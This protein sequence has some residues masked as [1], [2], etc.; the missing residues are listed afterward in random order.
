[1]LHVYVSRGSEL[2]AGKFHAQKLFEQK[3]TL[4]QSVNFLQLLHLTDAAGHAVSLARCSCEPHLT[5][6]WLLTGQAEA[7]VGGVEGGR[8]EVYA[9]TCF[10]GAVLCLRR[11]NAALLDTACTDSEFSPAIILACFPAAS[12]CVAIVIAF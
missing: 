2:Q 8:E 4:L 7:E 6:V 1:M 10:E 12:V 11:E 9:C 3:D 5:Q